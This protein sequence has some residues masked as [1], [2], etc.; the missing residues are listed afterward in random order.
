MAKIELYRTSPYPMRGPKQAHCD[1]TLFVGP[2]T[3]YYHNCGASQ[4]SGDVAAFCPTDVQ[5]SLGLVEDGVVEAVGEVLT[6]KP[7][8][9]SVVLLT[10]CQSAFSGIDMANVASRVES[11]YG[12]LCFHRENNRILLPKAHGGAEGDGLRDDR[13][14]RGG[15]DE[16]AALFSMIPDERVVEGRGLLFLG[17]AALDARN[18]LFDAAL[19]WRFDWVQEFQDLRSRSALDRAR[20]NDVAIIADERLHPLA[21]AM[22]DAWGLRYIVAPDTCSIP[23]VDALYTELGELC[24]AHAD[25]SRARSKALKA[26]ERFK[27][28]YD[29]S[30]GVIEV[31]A[32]LCGVD[33]LRAFGIEA[34]LAPAFA[35]RGR[36]KPMRNAPKADGGQSAEVAGKA[37]ATG[38]CRPID[39]SLLRSG[40]IHYPTSGLRMRRKGDDSAGF[41]RRALPERAAFWGYLGIEDFFDRLNKELM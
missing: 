11:A 12:I 15:K 34:A 7:G 16:L 14:R 39:A 24:G 31:S 21:K 20:S 28:G 38:A 17:N 1:F 36:F 40:D 9:E 30:I 37:S 27:A 3:C 6:A 25:V 18:E 19:Q 41:L 35:A 2:V 26:V 32:P 10:A 23:E 29:P 8:I 33:A 4:G 13:R 5:M 22:Q